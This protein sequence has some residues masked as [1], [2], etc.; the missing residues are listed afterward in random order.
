M[1]S[2]LH[3]KRKHQPPGR[4]GDNQLAREFQAAFQMYQRGKLAEAERL[5]L[6]L[7]RL[8]PS[9]GD[10]L[11]LLG[12]IAYQSG[13]HEEALWYLRD[14]ARLMDQ[15]PHI[16]NSSGW[17]SWKWGGMKRQSRCSSEPRHSKRTSP[18]LTTILVTP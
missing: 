6:K 5:F 18:K 2:A 14:G 1:V 12:L 10:V 16:I 15:S 8:V 7:R 13:R 17:C 3:N 4:A 9:N 11:H